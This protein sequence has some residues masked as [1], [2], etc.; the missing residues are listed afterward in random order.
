MRLQPA[1]GPN[2]LS[3]HGN[4]DML[5]H[6]HLWLL[7][8]TPWISFLSWA[9]P[10]VLAA[11]VGVCA[12]YRGISVLFRKD[13]AAGRYEFSVGENGFVHAA[14]GLAFLAAV[15]LPFYLVYFNPYPDPLEFRLISVAFVFLFGFIVGVQLCWAI[16]CK[17]KVR[18]YVPSHEGAREIQ[19]LAKQ[20]GPLLWSLHIKGQWDVALGLRHRLLACLRL[21][22]CEGWRRLVHSKVDQRQFAQ[23]L[24]EVAQDLVAEAERKGERGYS[25]ILASPLLP[26]RKK[27]FEAIREKLKSYPT[28]EW[29]FQPVKRRLSLFQLVVGKSVYGW[30]LRSDRTRILAEGV[31]IWH[32]SRP[33]PGPV[34]DA[35]R[36]RS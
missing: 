36:D 17:R 5:D 16:T 26:G 27:L 23:T 9:L 6:L 31:Q 33:R 13:R 19:I 30:K 2:A 18:T 14:A 11:A 1:S 28:E 29:D 10:V 32:Q 24:I 3:A 4:I 7:G 15:V 20:E 21:S 25:L 34:R 35:C 12:G 8:A 22:G